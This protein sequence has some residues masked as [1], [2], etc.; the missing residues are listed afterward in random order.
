[1]KQ[2]FLKLSGA[3]LL[4]NLIANGAAAQQEEGDKKKAEKSDL[5]IVHPKDGKDTRVTIEVKDGEVKVNGKPLSE[6]SDDNVTITKRKSM[7][8]GGF[9]IAGA[10]NSRFRSS[11]WSYNGDNDMFPGEEKAF[12][13]VTTDKAA[14]G[15]AKITTV[16]ENTAA[17][18]AGL[19]KGDVIIR[20][21][22]QKIASAEDL[23]KTIGKCKPEEK[24]TIVYKR[25][26]KEQ[27][28]S[29]A[30]GKRKVNT[31]T[32]NMAPGNFN[33][34]QPG[35]FNFDRLQGMSNYTVRGRGKLGIKAQ[36]TEE[37]KGVKVLEVDDESPADNAGIKEGDVITEFD[38]AEVNNVDKL[39]EAAGKA[40]A[41]PS[42]KV[43]LTRDGKSQEIQ[44][45]IPK[46]L[47][48]AN[49]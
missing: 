3:L 5:I 40:A 2:Y 43:K 25:D 22:D 9:M 30:L 34:D 12:L 15:G 20:I 26:G 28:Q 29:V 44:V 11:T 36:E 39:R 24:V 48:I 47:K 16:S 31:M 49:L 35:N 42:F 41:K 7:D 8:G 38:G 23:T 1:M 37:G 33:F 32:Y 45:K 18:K 21:N 17:E 10:P 19:K 4:L 46:N 6:F 14:E 13:G 27:S